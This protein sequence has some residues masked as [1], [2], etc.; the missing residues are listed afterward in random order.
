MNFGVL[1]NDSTDLSACSAERLRVCREDFVGKVF[2]AHLCISVWDYHLCHIYVNTLRFT[3]FI[4]VLTL[5]IL[6][7]KCLYYTLYVGSIQYYLCYRASMCNFVAVDRIFLS[8]ESVII[9]LNR[10]M[11]YFCK[12]EYID[13]LC[14]SVFLIKINCWINIHFEEKT[15]E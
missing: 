9:C 8:H 12:Y 7:E 14:S 5:D 4:V 10:L 15:P 6:I 1:V 13:P 3:I 11:S 2:I